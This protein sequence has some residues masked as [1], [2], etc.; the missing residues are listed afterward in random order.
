[1]KESPLTETDRVFT[2]FRRKP[3]RPFYS[4][5]EFYTG[6]I[7]LAVLGAVFLWVL[8]MG[9]HPDPSLFATQEKLLSAKGA[10]V[11]VYNRPL[12][13][14]VDPDAKAKPSEAASE[15]E[16]FP[17]EVV[18][19][20][21]KV[22][23]PV[24]SFDETDVYKKIDGREDFY[25]S[26]GFQRLHFLSLQS[27]KNNETIDIELFDL[28]SIQNSLGA[29]TAE[30]S[31]PNVP[32]TMQSSSLSYAATNSA[33]ATQ[34][35][36]YIRIIG[37][38]DRPEIREKISSLR[39]VLVSHFPAEKMPWTYALFVGEIGA[40]PGQIHYQRENAFSFSF[41]SD[42]YSAKVPGAKETELFIT[43]R[44]SA[45]EA[46]KLAKQFADGFG[47]YGKVLKQS[48]V[49]VQNEFIQTVEGVDSYDTY[50]IGIRFAK[51]Q[52][53]AVRWM[54]KLKKAL[55]KVSA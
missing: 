33:F 8:W 3:Y 48:P 6:L 30:I 5:R 37:S 45:N 22:T 49:L 20:G 16:P 53:E 54:D 9:A 25:K 46:A 2:T 50:V 1:M 43:K 44:P 51:S 12:E 29:L 19:D 26:F 55:K 42:V 24:Q 23:G 38:E 52:E 47:S 21:W 32:V 31:D 40:G 14:W 35:R 39:T 28:G 17:S 18:S 41:A 27:T 15:F 36:Y 10:L 7:L 4:L 13:R 34:G 11:P